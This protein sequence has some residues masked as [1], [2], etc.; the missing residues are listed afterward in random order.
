MISKI[1]NSKVFKIL[2]IV[3][4]ILLMYRVVVYFETA[5][6]RIS[7]IP[8][9]MLLGKGILILYV[10]YFV[11]RIM[12]FKK[13]YT[14][15]ATVVTALAVIIPLRVMNISTATY[16]PDLFRMILFTCIISACFIVVLVE[17]FCS[18]SFIEVFKKNW[19]AI[20]IFIV[21]SAI[22]FPAYHITYLIVVLPALTLLLTDI[23][24]EKWMEITDCFSAAYYLA[25]LHLFTRS[26]IENPDR[27]YLGRFLGSFSQIETGG[28]FCGGAIVC[29]LYLWFRYRNKFKK[30]W[31]VT[32]AAVLLCIYP[33]YSMILFSSRS[34]IIAL[35][36]LAFFAFIFMHGK[37]KKAILL[38]SLIVLGTVVVLTCAVVGFSFY[39]GH[40]YAGVDPDDVP[41]VL[42]R[43]MAITAKEY[44]E[45][46]FG[47]NSILN[48]IDMALSGR[49]SGWVNSLKQVR[50]L[51][52]PFEET[53]I[54]LELTITTAHNFFIM[55]LINYGLIGGIVYIIWFIAEFVLFTDAAVKKKEYILFAVIW[56]YY[57][58]GNFIFTCVTWRYVVGFIM[59][60][61][62]YPLI[63]VINDIRKSSKKDD[64]KEIE[65][66]SGNS[67]TDSL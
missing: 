36:G 50:L 5:V 18:G 3:F 10:I 53:P 25:F 45:G 8:R 7:D 64:K 48:N 35:F 15:I 34:T 62:Q 17:L 20:I 26:L 42:N 60:L 30:K 31:P 54:I 59:L 28:M 19:P 38:R 32:V 22:A 51:G 41:Y 40:K 21:L 61:A 24:K 56:I 46:T 6:E 66:K 43:F 63:W 57:C 39:L 4:Q 47:A 49:L 14:W 58:L 23:K 1:Q 13:V 52:H 33:M 27:N 29:V 11:N 16:G 37:G 44:S 12:I 55:W 65:E 67:R 9:D 2:F